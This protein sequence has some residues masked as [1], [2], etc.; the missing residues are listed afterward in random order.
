MARLCDEAGKVMA[1]DVCHQKPGDK[2]QGM[3][4]DCTKA[5]REARKPIGADFLAWAVPRGYKVK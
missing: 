5:W 1:C 4:E 3:C 2:Y